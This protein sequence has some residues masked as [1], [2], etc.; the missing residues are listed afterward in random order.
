MKDCT[1][2]MLCWNCN[3]N[4]VALVPW[5]DN[6]GLS[7]K[8]EMTGLACYE[9]VRNASFAMRKAIVFIEAMHL[10][11]RDGVDPTALH[12]VLLNLEEYLDG[13]SLDMPGVYEKFSELQRFYPRFF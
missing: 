7:N 9:H 4:E 2:Q 11:V 1:N 13:C 10:I 12:S 8:Y 6:Q 5:P 3:S